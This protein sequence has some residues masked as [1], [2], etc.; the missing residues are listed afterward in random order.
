MNIEWVQF[1]LWNTALC[2]RSAGMIKSVPHTTVS[3]QMWCINGI[4]VG[5]HAPRFVDKIL[6]S[7]LVERK[8]VGLSFFPLIN[9]R[10]SR[11]IMWPKMITSFWV[12]IWGYQLDVRFDSLFGLFAN[13][14]SLKSDSLSLKSHINVL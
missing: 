11:A 6:Q 12:Y 1:V 2:L 5:L 8:K 7:K 4:K 14:F 10:W 9:L 13:Y 3:P